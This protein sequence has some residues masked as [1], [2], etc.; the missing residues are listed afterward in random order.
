MH[1][2]E[3]RFSLAFACIQAVKIAYLLFVLFY[4]FLFGGQF[5]PTLCKGCVNLSFDKHP[6]KL[7]QAGQ[8]VL[9]LF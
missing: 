8:K 6:F 3:Y 4:L 7:L 2:Q 1:G 9:K 5:K